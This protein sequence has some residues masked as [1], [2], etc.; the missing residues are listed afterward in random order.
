MAIDFDPDTFM[1]QT[2]DEP[3]ESERTLIPPG[4]YRM[5]ID[6]FNRDAFETFEFTYKRGA[7][8]G[9]EGKMH[10][11]TCPIV[12]D[13]EEVKKA[14]GMERPKIYYQCTLDFDENGQLV[15]GPNRNIDLGKLRHAVG[16][17]QPGPWAISQLRG[18]GPFMA[19]VEHREG[20]RKD[21]SRFKIAEIVRFA[22]IR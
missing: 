11:F 20:K 5:F 18:A 22:P 10:K 2:V 1:T 19:K 15:T 13:D 12:V 9:Q 17:N 6:D 8:A 14:M 7:L 16:Q 3:L 4:E 21:G